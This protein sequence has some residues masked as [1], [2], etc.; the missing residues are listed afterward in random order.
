MS[1]VFLILKI[2]GIL[3]LVLL[4]LFILMMLSILF[5][6][7]RYRFKGTI[8]Y[9]FEG[10]IV[11][12]WLFHLISLRC[13]IIDSTPE[14]SLRIFGFPKKFQVEA[15]VDAPL[16]KKKKKGKKKK[17]KKAQDDS[18]DGKQ[19]KEIEP[20]KAT[21]EEPKIRG[22]DETRKT[23]DKSLEQREAKKT[24]AYGRLKQ[25][26]NI[27]YY[28]IKS[29]L[30]KIIEKSKDMKTFFL[31][32]KNVITDETNKNAVNFLIREAR[33]IL[34]HIAPRKIKAALMFSAGDPALTGQ[35]LGICS[36]LPF[37]Y[38]YD[39]NIS[40]DFQAEDFYI[41][42]FFD[43]KGYVRGF[44]LLVLGIR[45]IRNKDI[46]IVIKNYRK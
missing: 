42:G 15:E 12:S 1:I 31:N 34:R 32:I 45:V 29:V 25:R 7:F 2:L 13:D 43:I 3:L 28:K 40:P 14:I 20:A 27:I 17:Q 30:K 9:K 38:R 33:F 5:L 26:I 4:C 46:K 35:I 6:P 44:H 21:E 19:S 22:S 23:P 11:V 24:S 36:T 10:R 18:N 8:H 37:F 16:N 39:C 41:N